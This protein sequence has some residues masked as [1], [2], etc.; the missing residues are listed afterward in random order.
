[1]RKPLNII[2]VDGMDGVGKTV[3]IQTLSNYLRVR[4]IPFIVNH[5]QDN[6]ESAKICINKTNAFLKENPDG[7][8]VNDGSIAR[9]IVIDLSSNLSVLE[10]EDKYK[11][12][13]HDYQRTDHQYGVLNILLIIDDISVCNERILRRDRLW[14]RDSKGLE[15]PDKELSLMNGMKIFDNHVLSKNL[16][17]QVVETYHSDS[18]LDVHQL[19][20]DVLKEDFYIK[21]PSNEG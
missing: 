2:N 17:F 9:M 3:Q 19:I 6:I 1:M 20:L 7:I 4:N 21:K 16:K 15:D 5:L 14:G 10:I 13:L 12:I 8:V 11:E 18:I